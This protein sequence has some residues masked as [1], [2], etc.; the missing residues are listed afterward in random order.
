[1]T[2]LAGQLDGVCNLHVSVKDSGGQIIFLRRVEPG[3]AD[4]SY[5]IEVARLAAL[6][7]SVISRAREVLALH[8][9]SEEQVS[10]ELTPK[11]QARRRAEPVQIQLFE[12][13]GHQ[14]AGRIRSLNLDELRPV[15]AL[16][17]LAELQ[18]ELNR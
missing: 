15:D 9:K 10:G 18:E 11:K 5:G 13:V 3:A 17:L 4:R 8:E 6:P 1:M 16:K 7:Q 2:A 14:I 12:P